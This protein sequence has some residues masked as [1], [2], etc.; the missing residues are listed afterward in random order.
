VES[1]TAAYRARRPETTALYEVVRDNLETLYGAIDDGAL[2]VR[3]PKH[4]RK[5]LESYLD[6]GLVCRGF[7]RLRCGDCGETRLVAFSCK[8]RGFCPSCTGRRMNATAANLMERVLPPQSGLRQWVLTFPFSWRRRLA[9]DGAL[10]G[11]LTRLFVETVHAF[12]AERAA[13]EGAIGA[14][15]GA[16]TVVQRTSSDLRLNP[17]LHAVVLDGAWHDPGGGLTWQGL[18]HLKTSEVGEVLERLLRRIERHLRRRGLLRIDEDG[19]ETDAEGDPEG[20]LAV[21]AVSG[22][23][24]PAGPQW[25]SG[26]APLEPHALAYDKPLCASLDGFTLHAAT[27][28]G[29][30]DPS[31]REALLRY[32]LRPPIAQDRLEPRGDG[33]VRITLKKAYA[34]GTLAVDMDPLS[35]L[36]RLATSVPPPRFHTVHYAGVLAAASEWRSRLAPASPLPAPA[37]GDEPCRPQ[38]PGAYRPWAELLARSFAVDVFACPR[39]QGRMKLLAIVK[40][41]SRIARYLAPAGEPTE[42]PHR[43]PKRGPPYWKSRVLRRLALGDEDGGESHGSGADQT[44]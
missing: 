40:D 9:Q 20:K 27:R 28:A 36:C 22:Q 26:L 3:I 33:L 38:R 13:R 12:Y 1:C 2:A 7:A 6:C 17:H 11:R 44:A 25:L 37:Q 10:L 19:A 18:G 34:D 42:A 24:P 5:E 23:A 39:C 15:T 32:V 30:H 31:G 4:A 21:S 16:V 35:L 14:K 43:S 29:A 41:P 8:G